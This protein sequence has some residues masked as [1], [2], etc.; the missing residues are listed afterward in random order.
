M[1]VALTAIKENLIKVLKNNPTHKVCVSANDSDNVWVADF[2]GR[3]VKG[4]NSIV[5]EEMIKNNELVLAGKN[6]LQAKEYR[7][8]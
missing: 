5:I 7:M 2:E 8:V 6:W 3:F 4:T 1:N